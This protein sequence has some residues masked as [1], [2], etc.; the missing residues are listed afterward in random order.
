[1]NNCVYFFTFLETKGRNTHRGALLEA[2]V[3]ES[4]VN[5]S[6]MVKRM[7]ISRGTYYYHIKDPNLS[8]EQLAE[9]GKIIKHDFSQ[10]LPE[11]KRY[12]FE[13]PEV[14]YGIP[15]TLDEAIEQRNFWRE[16]YYKKVEEY[17]RLLVEIKKNPNS[18]I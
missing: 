18:E 12:V 4:S 1:M 5:I 10:D 17:N 11:M 3:R 13:E 9:Y 8:Y 16:R 14:P 2:A 15:K 6:Q 7:G